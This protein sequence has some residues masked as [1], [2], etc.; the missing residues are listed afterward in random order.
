[1]GLTAALGLVP[2]L[3]IVFV[4]T[5]RERLVV[6]VCDRHRFHWLVRL[7]ASIPIVCLVSIPVMYIPKFLD[8]FAWSLRAGSAFRDSPL[9]AAVLAAI[10]LPLFGLYALVHLTKVRVT[11]ATETAVTLEGVSERFVHAFRGDS[12]DSIA[13]GFAK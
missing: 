3:I 8:D 7:V 13:I 1:L 6:P 4:A 5:R 12:A 11:E 2:F 9:F 10:L